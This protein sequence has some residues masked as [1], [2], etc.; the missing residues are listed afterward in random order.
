M[1]EPAAV[2]IAADIAAGKVTALAVTEACLARIAAD[3]PRIGA[4]AH[5]DPDHART[6]AR[7]LDE[8]KRAGAMLGPL[9]GVPVAVKDIVDTADFPDRAGQ[10]DP[11]RPAAAARRGDRHPAAGGRCRP[12]RQDGDHRVRLLHAGQDPQPARPRAH[13]GRLLERLGGGRGRGDGAFGDRQPDQRLGDPPGLVLR[14]GRLQAELRPD[15]AHRRADHLG[16][17]GPCRGVRTFGR[18]RGFPGRCAGGVR[19][20]RPRDPARY[21]RRRCAGWR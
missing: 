15:P 11:C 3:E 7:A 17:A 18:G 10:R 16:H 2:E 4:F 12:A 21:P 5:L 8:R 19:R 6:Q 14:R 13:A 1:T 20:G 9:H